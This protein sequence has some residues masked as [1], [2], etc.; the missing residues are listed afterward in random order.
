MQITVDNDGLLI[1]AH[2]LS[3]SLRPFEKTVSQAVLLRLVLQLVIM[4][5]YERA[6]LQICQHSWVCCVASFLHVH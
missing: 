1:P 5:E 6:R 3:H 2:I 4:E